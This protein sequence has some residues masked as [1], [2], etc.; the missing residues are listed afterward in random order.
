MEQRNL[1]IA[2]VLSIAILIA[3]QFV[4]ERLYPPAP[5]HHPPATAP[6]Q[7]SAVG[8]SGVRIPA[9]PAAAARPAPAASIAGQ[10]RIAIDTPALHGSI[11]LA[12]ARFDNLALAKYHV[13]V[14]PKSPHV[15]LLRPNGAAN[16]YFA[17]F[18]W[19]ARG[20]GVKLPGPDTLWTPVT[21]GPL[22]PTHPVTLTWKNGAGLV[23]T[24]TI[25]VDRDYMFTLRDSVH[26]TGTAP[27]KLAPYG[28]IIRTGTPPVSGYYLLFEGPIGY[29]PFDGRMARLHR[30]VLA[31]IVDPA[32]GRKHRGRLQQ[33]HRKRRQSLPSR[34]RRCAAD[35][36]A[37]CDGDDIVAL[38]CRRQGV[39]HSRRLYRR[40]RPAV[41]P[42]HRFR[43]VLF[44]DQADLSDLAA[45]QTRNRQFR[46]R[47]SALYAAGQAAV[48]PACQQ[49]V[50][51]HEPHEA[52][53]TGDPEDSRALSR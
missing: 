33:D 3:F 14:D 16:A 8:P 36:R 37:R 7:R 1:L 38:L 11:A 51:R 23:F 42:C 15:V 50:Q 29:F 5:L 28:L 2:I 21:S 43:L 35:H 22:T 17:E 47:N 39:E 25:S 46:A 32:A 9:A 53:A 13:T 20:G 6:A 24:R 12:G 52:A 31:D 27:V 34:F 10:P 49:V 18:G 40:W 48:F 41:R 44:P 45:V 4:Y 19:A 30:Q 26:N